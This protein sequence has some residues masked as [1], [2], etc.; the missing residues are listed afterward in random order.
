LVATS[1]SNV[2]SVTLPKIDLSSST[3]GAN[4][5]SFF[6][7]STINFL[8]TTPAPGGIFTAGDR[9]PATYAVG[10]VGGVVYT[11][12]SVRKLANNRA[13]VTVPTS[14]VG[15]V[16]SLPTPYQVCIYGDATATGKLIGNSVYTVTVVPGVISVFPDAGPSQ[17][18]ATITVYGSNLPTAAASITATLGGSPLVVTPGSDTY[19]TAVTPLHAVAENVPLIVTTSIGTFTLTN[20]YDYANSITVSP[21]TGSN[22][23][24]TVDV[25]VTG[26]G[27]LSLP[28]ASVTA[29]VNPNTSDAHVYLVNG[30]YDPA[31]ATGD[32]AAPKGNGPVAECGNVQVVLD[33]ELF[34]TLQL[35]QRRNALGTFALPASRSVADFLSTAGSPIITSAGTSALTSADVGVPIVETGNA[36]IPAGTT[37]VSVTSPTTAVLSAN[38]LTTDS[39]VTAVVGGPLRAALAAG[40]T[41]TLAT[42]TSATVLFSQAD[43]GRPITGTGIPAG[44]TITAVANGAGTTQTITMSQAY[45]GSTGAISGGVTV[46][47]ASPVLNG[48]Y[49]LTIV[50]NGAVDAATTV[51]TYSQSI[52]SSG[53]MFTVAPF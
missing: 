14:G 21:N 3:G 10:T 19:F 45:T 30:V 51:N 20:A 49:T 13:G 39:T 11:A 1:G 24:T 9:C 46:N 53:S 2:Y 31:S 12:A 47:A 40:G 8:T 32:G 42:I 44:T 37:I 35:N 26:V 50:S 33:T 27:F 52:V 41:A 22:T 4:T 28:F 43:V 5:G 7:S 15:I 6:A 29:A 23:M 17:G 34:C 25:D 38:A 48:A 36:A 16:N 18:G